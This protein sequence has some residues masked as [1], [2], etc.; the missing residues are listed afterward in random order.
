MIP[1]KIIVR[2]KPWK[3][4]MG[5]RFSPELVLRMDVALSNYHNNIM[6]LIVLLECE[7]DTLTMNL[8]SWLVGWTNCRSA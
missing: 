4:N 5:F 1:R 7:G 2:L 3:Y 8:V 6:V